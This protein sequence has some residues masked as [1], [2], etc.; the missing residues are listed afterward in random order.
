MD[1]DNFTSNLRKLGKLSAIVIVLI[2][3][4]F[5]ALPCAVMNS[6]D[7]QIDSSDAPAIEP[8]PHIVSTYELNYLIVSVNHND[9]SLELIDPF[10]GKIESYMNLDNGPISVMPQPDTMNAAVL[11]ENPQQIKIVNMSTKEIYAD[12][13]LTPYSKNGIGT[14]SDEG[15]VDH[16]F[17]RHDGKYLYVVTDT[18]LAV[19]NIRTYAVEKCFDQVGSRVAADMNPQGSAVLL[20][21]K[22][23]DNTYVVDRLNTSSNL[24]D[25]SATLNMDFDATNV[26]PLRFSPDGTK[27]YTFIDDMG[28]T[29]WIGIKPNL[30]V[31]DSSTLDV[32]ITME[33][34][35]TVH[36]V[37]STN[38]MDLEISPDGKRLYMLYS[39]CERTKFTWSKVLVYD[40]TNSTFE[41]TFYSAGREIGGIALSPDG[42][43]LYAANYCSYFTHDNTISV[44]NACTGEIVRSLDVYDG[45]MDVKTVIWKK[46]PV[47]VPV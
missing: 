27:A 23:K 28:L 47:G 32:N 7:I 3:L 33:A 9:N 40:L 11:T 13:S 29:G 21:R 45:P 15:C 24:I 17:W 20:F 39:A 1:F 31:I 25:K 36:S 16:M 19:I 14:I 5:T 35:P 38:R 22:I 37:S 26:G 4:C 41:N 12:I 42:S 8:L 43:L 18:Y 6:S 30:I 44:L 10:S 2:I 46:P 34:L